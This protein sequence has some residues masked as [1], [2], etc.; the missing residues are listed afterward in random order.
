MAL[1]TLETL[2]AL[3][4]RNLEYAEMRVWVGRGG[5]GGGEEESMAREM[6]VVD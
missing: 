4:I 2:E 5:E 3:L 6:M 1:S